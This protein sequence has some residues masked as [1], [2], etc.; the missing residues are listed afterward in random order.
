MSEIRLAPK[1][2]PEEYRTNF[3]DINRALS[4]GAALAEASRC[5]FCFD[6][7][8][9][10]A[11]PTHIDVPAFIKKIATGNM[12]GSAREILSANIL[13]ASCARVCPVEVLCEGA[14]VMHGR[15]EPPI[16]IGRLQRHA[17]DWAFQ[18]PVQLFAPGSARDKRVAL[19]GAGPA[20]LS[21]AAELAKMGYGAVILDRHPLPGG[22]NTYGIAYYKMTP[23]ESLR[24]INLVRSLGVKIQCGVQVGHDLTLEDL[25][26]DFDAIFIGVGLGKTRRLGIPGEN[27]A[28]VYE[29]IDFI[30]EVKSKPFAEIDVG[31]RVVVIGAGNTSIDCATQ[32]RRLGAE[33]VAIV[34]RRGES[35][36]PAY[37]YEYELAK[38]DGVQFLWHAQPVEIQGNA[39]VQRL[40]CV[41]TRSGAR[42]ASGSF[43]ADEIPESRFFIETDMVIEAL[44]QDPRSSFLEKLPGV[45]LEKGRVVVDPGTGQTANPKYFSGGDCANGGKEVVDAV[46]DGKRAAAGIDRYLRAVGPRPPGL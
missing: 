46:A 41:R 5:L 39:F 42:E 24:E 30:E 18:N 17:T 4:P 27:L 22:L 7:P 29:A 16:Q 11:C 37:H 33:W 14:C 43:R 31:R 23:E 8:C 45:Q 6:A 1:L 38:Q 19:I 44:G 3:G 15:G 28:G 13:G 21:C 20:S 40:V 9:T 32:A 34:Y 25:E 12:R 36:M 35:E 10:A 2:R 26:A